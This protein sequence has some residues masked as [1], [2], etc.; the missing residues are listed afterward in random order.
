MRICHHL[1][2]I[3]RKSFFRIHF[4]WC[5]FLFFYMFF[6]LHIVRIYNECIVKASLPD[7]WCH[8]SCFDLML[9]RVL[10]LCHTEK[11][12]QGYQHP[13]KIKEVDTIMLLVHWC[14]TLTEQTFHT[15]SPCELAI[16]LHY[17][18]YIILTHILILMPT[19]L[20]F[21]HL[22]SSFLKTQC[23]THIGWLT[24][25]CRGCEFLVSEQVT[26]NSN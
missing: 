11:A 18:K 19:A 22:I 9:E 25:S 4:L 1:C 23:S 21:K 10:T 2:C 24:L 15:Y 3:L 13:K 8:T 17:L 5:V 6:F 20:N 26:T 14:A 12:P 16:L 7:I